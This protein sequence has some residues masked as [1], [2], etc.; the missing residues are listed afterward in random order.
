MKVTDTARGTAIQQ[1]SRLL[2]VIYVL[3]LERAREHCTTIYEMDS[4]GFDRWYIYRV[5]VIDG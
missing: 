4:K 3:K 2:H 1:S 5:L